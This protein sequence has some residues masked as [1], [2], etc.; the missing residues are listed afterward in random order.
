MSQSL[1][2]G[3]SADAK[4]AM[5]QNP[6]YFVWWYTTKSMLLVAAVAALAYQLGKN[7]RT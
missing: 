4:A 7:A 6:D 1:V 5:A 2:S 3:F